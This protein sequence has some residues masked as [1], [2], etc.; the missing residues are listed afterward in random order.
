M[1]SM[2]GFTGYII[3]LLAGVVFVV[4]PI[5]GYSKAKA[6]PKKKRRNI[7]GFLLGV[8]LIITSLVLIF[9]PIT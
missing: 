7:L 6:D 9:V 4:F 1:Y 2:N 3:P 5:L 8:F